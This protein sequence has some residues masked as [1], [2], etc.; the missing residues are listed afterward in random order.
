MGQM[1]V[2]VWVPVGVFYNFYLVLKLRCFGWCNFR[3][4]VVNIDSFS[5][6]ENQQE[7]FCLYRSTDFSEH[8]CHTGKPYR[9]AQ[10]LGGLQF[11]ADTEKVKAKSTVSASYMQETIRLLRQ[12][13]K[14][15]LAL[16]KQLISLGRTVW[17]TDVPRTFRRN[18]NIQL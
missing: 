5:N 6:L 7:C 18:V 4:L 17:P 12:R 13:L 8:I 3:L 1:Y 2:S 11:L 15:R 14:A 10:W 9:W 16:L